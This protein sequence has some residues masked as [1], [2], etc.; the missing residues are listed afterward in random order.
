MELT[1]FLLKTKVFLIRRIAELFGIFVVAG[2]ILIFISIL[3]YSPS[4]PNFIVNSD[5]SIKN[6]LGF[7]GMRCF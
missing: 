6:L 4:D 1:N 3:S 5:V 2:S 7:K